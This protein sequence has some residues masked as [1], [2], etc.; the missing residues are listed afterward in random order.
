MKIIL[1]VVVAIMFKKCLE[2][3]IYHL[4]DL[5]KRIVIE[6]VIVVTVGSIV[7]VAVVINMQWKKVTLNQV[8]FVI[9]I[10]T[11]AKGEF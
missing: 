10:I 3:H 8:M 4:N 5:K 9:I 1:T 7:M 11:A 6:M 2:Y